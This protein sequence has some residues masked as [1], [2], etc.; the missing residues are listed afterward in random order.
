M[1]STSEPDWSETQ[2]EL[3]QTISQETCDQWIY[4]VEQVQLRNEMEYGLLTTILTSQ[5]PVSTTA[6]CIER[7]ISV[8][9]D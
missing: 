3:C 5:G 6:P 4:F 2:V 7:D 1:Y 9:H 8:H